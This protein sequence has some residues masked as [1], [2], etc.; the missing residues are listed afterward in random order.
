MMPTKAVPE[1]IGSVDDRFHQPLR[2]HS[3]K[4]SLHRTPGAT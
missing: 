2:R 3:H 4:K 1:P